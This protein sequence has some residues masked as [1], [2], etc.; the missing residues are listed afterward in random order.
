MKENQQLPRLQRIG[1]HPHPNDQTSTAA[2]WEI[3]LQRKE[4]RNALDAPFWK[5]IPLC[6]EYLDSLPQCRCI[7]LT[8]EGTTFCA[9]ID[10]L[11]AAEN[12][13][14]S[15]DEES[16]PARLSVALRKYVKYLQSAINSIGKPL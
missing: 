13:Q 14:I 6:F 5:E 15:S 4:K 16:D 1:V 3:R 12:L 8:A 10:L 2:I 11:Y 7:L 9:G